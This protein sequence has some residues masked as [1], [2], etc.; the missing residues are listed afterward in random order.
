MAPPR[1]SQRNLYFLQRWTPG[2]PHRFYRPSGHALTFLL[3]SMSHYSSFSTMNKELAAA[4]YSHKCSTVPVYS[5]TSC[6]ILQDFCKKSC[7]KMFSTWDVIRFH[8]N[9]P[10]WLLLFRIH[11]KN[12]PPSPFFNPSS[13]P[14]GIRSYLTRANAKIAGKTPESWKSFALGFLYCDHPHSR[15]RSNWLGTDQCPW[16]KI[17]RHLKHSSLHR[18]ATCCHL[19]VCSVT[20]LAIEILIYWSR[21]SGVHSSGAQLFTF[22]MFRCSGVQTLLTR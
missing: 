7:G 16:F 21:C 3:D 8:W 19:W 9:L 13:Q 14:S 20:L 2:V 12:T 10:L 15:N 1:Q 6:T 17:S 11:G 4:S 18:H 22:Q 5:H